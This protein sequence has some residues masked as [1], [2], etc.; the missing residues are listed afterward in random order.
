[1]ADALEAALAQRDDLNQYGSAKRMLFALQLS[2]DLED[3]HSI[4][5]TALTDGPDDKSCDLVYIDRDSHSM[6]LA[7]GYEAGNVN[8]AQAPLTKATSLH[9]AVNWLFGSHAE[10]DV[11]QRLRSAWRELNEAL[12]DGVIENIEIWFVHNLP[13]NHQIADELRA[14]ANAAY[15]IIAARYSVEDVS[16]T[17]TEVG[18]ETLSDRYEGS[19]TPILVGDEFTI[20]VSGAF[21]ESG[22][23]WSALCASI[24]AT[25][26]RDQF[27]VHKER[28]FSANIRGYLGSTRSQSNINN[29]I[30][31]TARDQPGRFWAYNNGITALVHSFESPAGDAVKIT[32]IAIVNGAQTTGAIGS[33]ESERMGDVRLLARFIKCDDA[34]TVQDI[35]RYNNRQNPTQASDFRSND[36]VQSRLVKD[37]A[38]LGVVGYNGGRRGGAEDVIRRPGENQLAASVAAQALAAFHGRPDVSYHE[39]GQIWEQDDI[40]SSVFPERV[41]ARHI[42]FVYSLLR[43]LEQNKTSLNSKSS[44]PQTQRDRDLAKWFGMRGST[45]LAVAAIGASIESVLDV[46]VSDRYNLEFKKKLTIPKAIEAWRPVI[47]SLLS[48]APDQLSAPL[49]S[50]GGLRNRTAVDAAIG[51]YRA[52]VSATSQVNK[53]IYA[54]FAEMVKS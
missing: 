22:E 29:G 52:V 38:S 32:G 3:I 51:T 25:W 2:L 24:P 45:F 43:A 6:I 13:E 1:M 36:R 54:E 41:S 9:Q 21:T 8:Q 34:A 37:F 48:L 19:R 16:V 27:S 4:A 12:T 15:R 49:L 40:Y 39:K 50:A 17:G 20:P 31:A 26:L 46:P 14:V 18:R 44:G 53:P 10:S 47:T 35:I 7:Q 33:T 42:L 5:A 11:P 23:N 30:Q 28:L